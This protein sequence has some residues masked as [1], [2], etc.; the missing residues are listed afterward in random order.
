MTRTMR[1]TRMKI[2][3]TSQRFARGPLAT[4]PYRVSGLGSLH[5]LGDT[6]ATIAQIIEAGYGP[7]ATNVTYPV[8]ANG[9][10]TQNLTV[11][12]T[13]ISPATPPQT[14]IWPLLS[15]LGIVGV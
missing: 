13:P 12:A 1:R 11:P 15:I 7:T 4:S 9:N 8:D 3:T 14:P 5:G 6:P 2:Q 10:V